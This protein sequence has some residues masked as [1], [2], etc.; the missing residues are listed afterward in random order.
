[1]VAVYPLGFFFRESPTLEPLL[2]AAAPS[3]TAAA[4]GEEQDGEISEAESN[5]SGVEDDDDI[6]ILNSSQ[7]ELFHKIRLAAI[8]T[9]ETP[10]S[11]SSSSLGT[12]SK[13]REDKLNAVLMRRRERKN[14]AGSDSR[15]QH[16]KLWKSKFEI[17][18]NRCN[19][20]H[21]IFWGIVAFL[22]CKY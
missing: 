16:G 14:Y 1:V 13:V 21:E 15:Q 10:P 18:Y 12:K 9:E 19:F 7:T 17:L 5:L 3:A 8:K 4:P 11:S 20:L 22:L 6:E 2:S